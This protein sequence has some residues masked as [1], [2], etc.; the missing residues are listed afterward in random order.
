M[1][2]SVENKFYCEEKAIDVSL[3]YD[4]IS[5]DMDNIKKSTPYN[6][7][8]TGQESFIL[9]SLNFRLSLS[10]EEFID[11]KKHFSYQSFI[12]TYKNGGFEN[13]L[14][15]AS[16]FNLTKQSTT[17]IKKHLKEMLTITKHIHIDHIL[18]FLDEQRP[19]MKVVKDNI[20]IIFDEQ[21]IEEIN[22]KWVIKER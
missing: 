3:I 1:K 20:Y 11:G 10:F 22:K 17:L 8:I 4:C 14:A 18:K 7:E 16:K 6:K 21:S 9:M 12:I 13:N 19:R 2:P 15:M 5:S